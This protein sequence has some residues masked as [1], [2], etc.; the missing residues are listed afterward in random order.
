MVNPSSFTDFDEA[1][2]K[3]SISIEFLAVVLLEIMN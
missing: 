3:T 2:F 1:I